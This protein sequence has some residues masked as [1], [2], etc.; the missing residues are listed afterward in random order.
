MKSKIYLIRF[1]NYFKSFWG[2][3]NKNLYL[4]KIWNGILKTGG[5]FGLL[6]LYI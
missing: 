1:L 3:F 4:T 2:V 5:G 6:Q